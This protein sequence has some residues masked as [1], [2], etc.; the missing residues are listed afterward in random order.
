MNT[1]ALA[2][3]LPT[4]SPSPAANGPSTPRDG[5]PGAFARELQSAAGGT[6]GDGADPAADGAREAAS[7]DARA[8]GRG[9]EAGA[10]PTRPSQ[11]NPSRGALERWLALSRAGG[12]DRG[13][14]DAEAKV[15]T[16][17][18]GEPATDLPRTVDDEATAPEAAALLAALLPRQPDDKSAVDPGQ[19]AEGDSPPD[20]GALLGVEPRPTPGAAQLAALA[21]RQAAGRR[22]DHG[23]AGPLSAAP[24]LEGAEGRGSAASAAGLS[25]AIGGGPA[26]TGTAPAAPSAL[27]AF[28]AELARAGQ[29]VAGTT[30]VTAGSPASNITLSTPVHG[31]EFMPRLS[32]ELAVL[33][34][35]G[36]QEAR[37]HVNP[38]ELGPI[39][40]QITLDG[41]AAQVRLAVE[42]AQTRDLLEQGMP[43][44]AA[45]LRENGLTL[46]GGG[47]FQQARDP[48]RDGQGGQESPSRG[49]S[50]DGRDAGRDAGGEALSAVPVRRVRHPGQVDVYA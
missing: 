43:T 29:A 23:A 39:A 28:A 24:A 41:S 1:P 46:T 19:R 11:T 7:D 26:G 9:T 6:A 49:G 45:A 15:E 32:G 44:L 2:P 37:V 10:Q 12:A 50:S 16:A 20:D 22:D 3:V 47:V 35:D 17:A 42:H 48:G 4:P 34:R 31:T 13:A 14:A 18:D 33:A 25:E 21:A 8:D 36:V 5:E 30:G 40:V 38:A 27:P